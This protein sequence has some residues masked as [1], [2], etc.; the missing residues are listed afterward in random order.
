MHRFKHLPKLMKDAVDILGQLHNAPIEMA[1]PSVLGVANFATQARYS[2]NPGAYKP[3]PTSLFFIALAPT[4]GSKST[5]YG[6]LM[7][8]IEKWKES[9][10]VYQDQEKQKFEIDTH[11]YDTAMKAA[12]ELAVK[13]GSSSGITYPVKPAIPCKNRY[14]TG[15]GTV[16]GLV[17]MLKFHP[18]I[19]LFSSEAGEFFKSHAF[20]GGAGGSERAS[21]M[22]TAL[23]SMWDGQQVNKET[24]MESS[25]LRDRRVCMLMLIQQETVKTFLND[26]GM[27]AQGFTHRI[28]LSHCAGFVKPEMALDDDAQARTDA[29]RSNLQEFHDR[30]Y[31]LLLPSFSIKQGTDFELELPVMKQN[32]EARRILGKFFNDNRAKKVFE[33][34]KW[35]GFGQRL[36]E[37]ALRLAA[38]CA[39]FEG[40]TE[41]DADAARAGLE[42][43][44][45][46]IE[47]RKT[48]QLDITPIAP[49]KVQDATSIGEWIKKN[50]WNGTRRELQQRNACGFKRMDK[51]QQLTILD[52]AIDAGLIEMYSEG[53]AEKYRA[54]K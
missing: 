8:G 23:T 18:M 22:G 7:P 49:A 39:V 21:E 1:L 54:V 52:E 10:R 40:K 36:H 2:V 3:T 19:G 42:L 38:T 14:W 25:E 33:N 13:N 28:L 51:M 50:K 24:G 53:R 45:F 30:I 26:A 37:Q 34:D 11:L 17:E 15:K 41:I 31:S 4:G 5:I 47:Q 44:E 29:I 9:L 6:E 35:D 20:Q 43:I 12:K 48:L 27:A 16:N 46:F 32:N